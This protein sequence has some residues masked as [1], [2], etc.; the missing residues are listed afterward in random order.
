MLHY[1]A[2]RYVAAI[3]DLQRAA[4]LGEDS[5]V[6][7]FDLALV[8]LARGER[9]AALENLTQCLAHNPQ[10]ADARKLYDSLVGR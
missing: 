9:A 7:L 10:Q 4:E 2:K 6:V 8:N 5:P 3:A 1:R